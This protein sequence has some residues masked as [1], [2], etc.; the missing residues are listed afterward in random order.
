MT[1][2]TQDEWREH[3][4]DVLA[5]LAAAISLLHNGGAAAKKAAPSNLMFD[6]MLQDYEKSLSRARR[7]LRK[8]EN[9]NKL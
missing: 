3:L 4:I 6:I 5:S 2:P 1:E 7:F 9:K 8:L